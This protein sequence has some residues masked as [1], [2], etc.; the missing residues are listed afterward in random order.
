MPI[1]ASINDLS[2]LRSTAIKKIIAP[3]LD[4][5][6]K[7]NLTGIHVQ[8]VSSTGKLVFGVTGPS[9]QS[10]NI[11]KSRFPTS[12]ERIFAH[13]HEIWIAETKNPQVYSL[14]RAYFHLYTQV[15]VG[16]EDEYILLHADP[17]EPKGSPHHEYKCGPHLHFEFAPHPLPR[18]HIAL[19][20]GNLKAVINSIKELDIAIHKGISMLRNQILDSV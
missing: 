8:S 20:L 5:I 3:I 12:V 17:S 15:G 19:N 9:Q 14:E 6:G 1:K 7:R 11:D 2:S 10:S 18:A 13:Y 4:G 16:K